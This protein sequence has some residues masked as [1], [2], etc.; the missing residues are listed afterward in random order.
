MRKALADMKESLALGLLVGEGRGAEDK[1]SVLLEVE[2][3]LQ[4]QYKA[5]SSSSQQGGTTSIQQGFDFTL[6]LAEQENQSLREK[7]DDLLYHLETLEKL[8]EA[9]TK[10]P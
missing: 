10:R 3:T 8:L 7:A 5:T 2:K 9:D 4:L 1:D 6:A